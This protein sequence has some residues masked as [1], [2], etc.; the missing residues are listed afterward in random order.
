MKRRSLS[1][2]GSYPLHI[3]CLLH[4]VLVRKSTLLIG[5]QLDD[6]LCLSSS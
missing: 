6:G 2:L 1:E 4:V 3:V 5:T